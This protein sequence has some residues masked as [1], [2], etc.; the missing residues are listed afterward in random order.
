MKTKNLPAVGLAIKF[1]NACVGDKL[2]GSRNARIADTHFIEFEVLPIRGVQDVHGFVL[3]RLWMTLG[4]QTRMIR[5][6]IKYVSA[7][8]WD[9]THT[10]SMILLLTTEGKTIVRLFDIGEMAL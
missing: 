9:F 4:P 10:R 6:R 5:P 8:E 3:A 7:Y 2:I 1:I